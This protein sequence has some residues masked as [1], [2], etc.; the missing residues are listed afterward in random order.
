MG[1]AYARFLENA[2]GVR[3]KIIFT[4]P[5]T[6]GADYAHDGFIESM[7]QMMMDDFRGDWDD[8]AEKRIPMIMKFRGVSEAEAKSIAWND[9]NELLAS[10]QG[11]LF[12]EPN[13]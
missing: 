4:S 9:I 13:S 12:G 8:I 6:I 7:E 1:A 2:R 10:K 3:Q 11:V 5:L